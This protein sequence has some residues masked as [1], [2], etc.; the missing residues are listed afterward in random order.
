MK[1]KGAKEE[2]PT[3]AAKQFTH[4]TALL[5]SPSSAPIRLYIASMKLL[6]SIFAPA[7]APR[8]LLAR[9]EYARTADKV[10]LGISEGFVGFVISTMALTERGSTIERYRAARRGQKAC[11]T[12]SSRRK[13]V[14]PRWKAEAVF[15]L[16]RHIRI[17]AGMTNGCKAEAHDEE[18]AELHRQYLMKPL[19]V[20]AS[21]G[22]R[23]LVLLGRRMCGA[24]TKRGVRDV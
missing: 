17:V 15:W 11:N 18:L 22:L 5:R 20:S 2:S 13:Q 7:L 3:K 10:T 19:S 12:S 1:A 16:T 23:D 9:A 6:S 4:Q 8:K 14:H 21:F 24:E